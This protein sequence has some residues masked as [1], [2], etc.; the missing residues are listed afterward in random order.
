MTVCYHYPL[1]CG[2][3]ANLSR[4]VQE[5]NNFHPWSLVRLLMPDER[6][7]SADVCHA[8][9]VRVYILAPF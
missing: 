7:A 3:D 2:R 5:G 9:V 6:G 4:K 8:C 1:S